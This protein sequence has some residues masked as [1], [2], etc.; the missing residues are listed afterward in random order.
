[1]IDDIAVFD[2]ND[3]ENH[4]EALGAL[5]HACVHDG[6]SIGFVLPFSRRESED[7][8]SRNVLPA[9]R[10]GRRR[11]LV[12]RK[13]GCIAGTGQLDFDTPPNQPHRA[14][15]RKLMVH[16]DFRRQG[17]ARALMVELE[18]IAFHL[19]RGL[20]TLDTR[21]GDKAEPLYTALGYH[22]AGII[23]GYCRDPLKDHL[24][25]TTIMYKTI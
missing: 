8:W 16:P 23:P 22:T 5:L 19:G 6:A 25:P 14:E 17:I 10:E 15:I 24:D 1:M 2:A 3:I 20:I 18:N 9:I 11:L 4:I 12:I 13:N 21:T 7:F